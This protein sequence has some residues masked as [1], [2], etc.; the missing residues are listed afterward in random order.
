MPR[1]VETNWNISHKLGGRLERGSVVFKNKHQNKEWV[2]RCFP[3]E[4]TM[5]YPNILSAGERDSL[6]CY[7][8]LEIIYSSRYSLAYERAVTAFLK[9]MCIWIW[10]TLAWKSAKLLIVMKIYSVSPDN[11]VYSLLWRKIAF[12]CGLWFSWKLKV[13]LCKEIVATCISGLSF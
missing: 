12:C 9:F 6:K 13:C 11:L 5:C 2:E 7:A 4:M 1:K 3:A 8:V 10:L